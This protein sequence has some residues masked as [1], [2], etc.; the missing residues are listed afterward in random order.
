M[1]RKD[2]TV[3]Q[4]YIHETERKLPELGMEIRLELSVLNPFYS[5]PHYPLPQKK[6]NKTTY[7]KEL[8]FLYFFL[9]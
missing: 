1:P 4:A 7:G 5:V 8:T 2:S 3:I 9:K 6:G